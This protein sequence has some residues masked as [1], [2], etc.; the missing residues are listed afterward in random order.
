MQVLKATSAR[1]LFLPYDSYECIMNEFFYLK[2][3]LLHFHECKNFKIYYIIIDMIASKNSYIYTFDCFFRVLG[4]IKI[5]IRQV[6]VQ[7]MVN[8]SSLLLPKL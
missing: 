8:I 5:K 7:L 6:L 2:R 3:K 4:G 1:K